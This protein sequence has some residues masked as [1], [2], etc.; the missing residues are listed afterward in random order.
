LSI[1]QYHSHKNFKYF[2]SIR[3]IARLNNLSLTGSI[4]I[5]LKAKQKGYSRSVKQAIEQMLDRGIRLSTT[6]INFALT[7]AGEQI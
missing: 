7:Q 1:A 3:R 2:N 4:V 6:V 5:L